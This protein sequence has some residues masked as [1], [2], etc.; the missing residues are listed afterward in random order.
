[1]KEGAHPNV[2]DMLRDVSMA[3]TKMKTRSLGKINNENEKINLI[4]E[5]KN[6]QDKLDYVMKSDH[7]LR[8]TVLIFGIEFYLLFDNHIMNIDFSDE[9]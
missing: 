9:Q 7:G 3:L 2:N 5:F 4:S 6:V 1:M 8:W